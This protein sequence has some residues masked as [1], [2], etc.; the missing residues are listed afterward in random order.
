MLFITFHYL[1]LENLLFSMEMILFQW[2]PM[3]ALTKTTVLQKSPDFFV[4][5]F[6]S[7]SPPGVDSGPAWTGDWLAG[8]SADFSS[9]SLKTICFQR[10]WYFFDSFSMYAL[11]KTTVLQK[12]S[13]FFLFFSASPPRVDSSPAWTGGWLAGRLT[14]HQWFSKT[15][16]FVK[17]SIEFHDLSMDAL[18]KT[19]VLQTSSD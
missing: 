14:S 16:V 15:V 3:D 9:F 19:T 5:C 18:T 8:W 6:F 4:F 10:K 17:A 1:L 12:S 2:F 11:T 13:D 7:A